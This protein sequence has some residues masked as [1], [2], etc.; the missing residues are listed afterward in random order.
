[1]IALPDPSRSWEYE[2]G[3]YLTCDITRVSK[4]MAH[5]ELVKMV[6]GLPGAIVECGVFKGAS[7]TRFAALRELMGSPYSKAIVGFDTFGPFPET[8]YAAD[9]RTR[10]QFVAAAGEESIGLDQLKEVLARKGTDRN[11]ELVPGDILETVPSYLDR[12]PELRISLLNLDT[13]IYEPAKV[14]LEHLYPRIVPG[15]LLVLD[16]YGTFAGETDAVDEY[17]RDAPATIEKF[18]FAMTPCFVRKP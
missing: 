7:L 11:V 6:A 3:F 10:E 4:I 14:I 13:D 9:V 8:D 15:G 17:F 12:N 5:Y 2:N 18:P 16:D 1:M